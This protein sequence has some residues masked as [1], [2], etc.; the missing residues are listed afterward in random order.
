MPKPELG[1]RTLAMGMAWLMLF[2]P[3]T[4]HPTYVFL[5]PSLA[6]ALTRTH[7]FTW[8]SLLLY[9]ASILVL[10]LGWSALTEGIQNVVPW[11]LTALPGGTTLFT[12]WL[13]AASWPS[14]DCDGPSG[15]DRLTLAMAQNEGVAR[16][17]TA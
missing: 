6:C 16:Q 9:L 10:V 17:L 12:I 2:G 1:I 15:A 7:S 11:T 3:S 5:A 4:E 13:V 14:R 8:I